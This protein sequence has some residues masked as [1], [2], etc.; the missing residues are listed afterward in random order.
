MISRIVAD[1]ALPLY[2]LSA[3]AA[4]KI[5]NQLKKMEK[6][7]EGEIQSVSKRVKRLEENQAPPS[8]RRAA[9]PRAASWADREVGG[10][11]NYPDDLSWPISDDEIEADDPPEEKSPPGTTISL[12]EDNSRLVASSTKVLAPDDR[13]RL[14]SAFP[15]PELQETRCPRLDPIFKT[16]SIQKET[17]VIDAELAQIP[18]LIHDPVA[19]LIRLL[20]ACDDDGSVL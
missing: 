6:S 1:R 18:A 11:E 12:S 16:A 14:R 2:R 15:C 9:E 20:H 8:K 10:L 7:L 3:S 17:K 13:K 19:P 5:L 4:K